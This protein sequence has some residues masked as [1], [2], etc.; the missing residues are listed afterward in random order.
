MAAVSSTKW[1]GFYNDPPHPELN[2]ED[3]TSTGW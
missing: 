2:E 1:T 3:I